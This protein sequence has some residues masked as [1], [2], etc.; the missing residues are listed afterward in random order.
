MIA[1]GERLD[2]CTRTR[3]AWICGGSDADILGKQATMNS[4]V[5]VLEDTKESES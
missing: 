5:Q 4:Q 3:Y 1:N 2:R